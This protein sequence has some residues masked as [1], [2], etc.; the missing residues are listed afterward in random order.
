[1]ATICIKDVVPGQPATVLVEVLQAS[2]AQTKNGDDYFLMTGKDR[3]GSMPFR[4]WTSSGDS[5]DVHRAKKELRVGCI[6]RCKTSKA[7]DFKGT[8][9]MA[10]FVYQV[11]PDDDP[12][13][14]QYRTHVAPETAGRLKEALGHVESIRA[15]LSEIRSP[16]LKAMCLGYLEQNE[17]KIARYPAA[18]SGQAHHG[19][20]GGY[21]THVSG[22]MDLARHHAGR[23]KGFADM[24]IVLAGAFFH[25]VGKFDSYASKGV[26]NTRAGKLVGHI[27]LGVPIVTAL[28]EKH[29]VGLEDKTM[30][31]HIVVSHHGRKEYGSCEQPKTIEAEIVCWADM[32][33]SK[34]ERVKMHLQSGVAVDEFVG[35]KDFGTYTAYQPED[36]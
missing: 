24:D 26:S 1:M 20:L 14:E 19:Y 11:V 23:L 7:S 8:A 18:P 35:N 27:A 10:N 34:A 12:K 5:S 6:A 25:D 3:T 17:A 36:G 15:M 31:Q 29:G 9:Q 32:A 30:I 21:A 16:K 28:C 33:D 4:I 2:V 13:I 22:V